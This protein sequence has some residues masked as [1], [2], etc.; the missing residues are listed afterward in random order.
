MA[1]VTVI[2]LTAARQKAAMVL[3]ERRQQVME[4]AQREVD[5]IRAA[6]D[7]LAD[8]FARAAGVKDGQWYF[9]QE[10]PGEAIVLRRVVEEDTDGQDRTDSEG[11][12][13]SVEKAE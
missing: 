3:F 9:D 2:T 5:E 7:E 6:V 11:G 1:E 8:T 10:G 13:S 12:E 4:E